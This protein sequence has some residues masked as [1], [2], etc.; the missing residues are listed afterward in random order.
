MKIKG[1]KKRWMFNS[2]GIIIGIFTLL[3]I[4]FNF[5]LQSYF[6]NGI[7]Q[8][9]MGC[10]EQSSCILS[11]SGD[12]SDYDFIEKSVKYIK[13]FCKN[14]KYEVMIFNESDQIILTS[15]GFLPEDSQD[16][17]DYWQAKNSSEN[18]GYWEGKNLNGEKVMGVSRAIYDKDG[19]Y[20]GAVRYIT[21]LEVVRH[22]VLI[23]ML[24][25]LLLEAAVLIFLITSG[26]YFIKSIVDPVT[27]ICNKSALIAQRDFNV[28][29]SKKYDDEIGKLS[30]AI[31]YMAKE[32]KE[33]EKLKN[34]FVSSISHELRTPLTAIKGWA[35]TMQI[36][37]TDSSTMKRG[38]EVI[39][40]EAGRLSGIVEGMLDFSSIREK[41]VSLVKEKIDIL[42]ELGEAVYMFK[43][44]A[45]S[46]NKT[47]IYSE[48]KMMPTVL[49]DKNRL[50]QVFINILDNAL[51][52]TSEGGG[53]SVSVCE[54]EECVAISVTDNGCGIPVEHLPN[55]TKKFYKANYSQ[56]GSGIGL[57]IVDEIVE[58]HGGKLDIISEEG[59]GT[60]VTITLPIFK[61]PEES[62]VSEGANQ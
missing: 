34:D 2:L 31:N 40:K 27:D 24:F 5:L 47:L 41:K 29:I 32:L 52:Y 20:V 39:V 3:M 16:A 17:P 6:Y 62:E 14:E 56:R 53:I 43:N 44:K 10:T 21:S 58:L 13:N 46:E 55:V 50:K 54:K 9:L 49:G 4:C 26:T 51:K 60:T 8:R 38:L 1:I 30:D 22:R 25:L 59:F 28:E 61:N 19:N 23:I 12:D 33:S 35:E 48:P 7:K 57:A 37:E 11:E 18:I 36:C 15:V 42:A 45:K